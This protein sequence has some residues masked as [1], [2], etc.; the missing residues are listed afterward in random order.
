MPG[1]RPRAAQA[2]ACLALRGRSL[3]PGTRAVVVPLNACRSC[4]ALALKTRFAVAHA[5]KRMH[6]SQ[7]FSFSNATIAEEPVA[8]PMDTEKENDDQVRHP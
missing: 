5:L 1:S 8:L 6:L 2:R 3:Q 4:F 7:R